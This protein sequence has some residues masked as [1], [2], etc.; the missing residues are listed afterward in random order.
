MNNT[1]NARSLN[2][3]TILTIII[4]VLSEEQRNKVIALLS[5]LESNIAKSNNE[6]VPPVLD[7]LQDFLHLIK[8][9][10]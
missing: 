5:E 10:K 3:R 9:S 4:A 8:N 1:I 2:N 6:S 7:D